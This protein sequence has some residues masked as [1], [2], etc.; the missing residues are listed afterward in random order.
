MKKEIIVAKDKVHLLELIQHE[1]TQY[2]N[3]CDLNHIDVS[4]LNDMSELFS[5]SEFNGDISMWDVSNVKDMK[6]MFF[7]SN[8]NGDVSQWN[9]ISLKSSYS[10][11]I[12]CNCPMPYWANLNTNEEICRTVKAYKLNENLTESLSVKTNSK[13]KPKI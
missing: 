9:P 6:G 12:E 2:G 13:N 4:Q 7:V 1:I 10:I 3:T 11:F 8:F 5:F